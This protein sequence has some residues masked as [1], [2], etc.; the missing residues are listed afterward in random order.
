MPGPKW[1]GQRR[2]HAERGRNRGDGDLSG[3][4]VLERVDL[5]PHRA[6]IA[7]DAA[8]PVQRPLP[9]GRKTLKPRAALHQHDAEDFLQLL[10]AGRHRRLGHAA[11]LGGASKVTFLGQRQQQFKLVDQKAASLLRFGNEYHGPRFDKYAKS[12]AEPGYV[13]ILKHPYSVFKSND[14]IFL[15]IGFPYCS[16]RQ[17]Y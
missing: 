9:L 1:R 3:Q 2:D 8:R 16:M 12:R 15:S 4:A 7:D 14:F 13:A 6:G 11:G 17:L 10:E 5:L